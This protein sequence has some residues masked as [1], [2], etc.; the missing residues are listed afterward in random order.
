[1]VHNTYMDNYEN[2]AKTNKDRAI[3]L[4]GGPS[5]LARLLGIT[6]Q[7]VCYWHRVPVKHLITVSRVSG[8]PVNELVPECA[9]VSPNES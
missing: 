6:R 1:M 4:A 2:I 7:G 3:A 8:V 5:V 9:F